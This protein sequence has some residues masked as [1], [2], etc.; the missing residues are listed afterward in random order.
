L[1]RAYN[2][3]KAA[4]RNHPE[5]VAWVKGY[6]DWMVSQQREDGSWPRTW[7]PGTNTV[8][9]P[10]GSGSYS[11]PPLLLAMYKETGDAK[12]KES[13]IRAGEYI[14]SD[15]GVRGIYAGGAVDGS[16]VH[17]TTDKEA[18]ML[19][20][21]AF[22]SIYDATKDPKWLERAKSAGDYAES[23]IWIWNVP[24][25]ADGN[26]ATLEWKRD[27]TTV[28]LQ[29]IGAAGSGGTDEYLDWA[30]P[31]YAKLYEDTKDPH[32]LEV[33]KI[34]LHNTKAMVAMPGHFYEMLG[35]GWQQEHW[36]MA[37]N[38]GYGQLGKWLPWCTTNHIHSIVALQDEHPALYRQI[39]T[40]PAGSTTRGK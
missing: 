12:Y 21:L 22:Q 3:E 36:I 30:T 1:M 14:W 5:W 24:M 7:V 15:W 26:D 38:R 4:G 23:W 16:S 29:G 40:P 19:S 34:L 39:A 18:G 32:Y 25:P 20:L 6:C 13:A 35:P 11:P 9:Q 2:R 10:S 31:M 28:G 37:Q 8:A 33:T 27:K 17:L